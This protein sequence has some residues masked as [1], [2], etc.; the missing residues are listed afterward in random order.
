MGSV[1][2]LK[3]RRTSRIAA[4]FG[5]VHTPARNSWGH[6]RQQPRFYDHRQER[7]PPSL[8]PAFEL[9]NICPRAR[10]EIELPCRELDN[11]DLEVVFEGTTVVIPSGDLN[12]P[13]RVAALLKT[14]FNL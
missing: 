14:E 5:D 11:G 13:D 1:S 2:T 9:P 6:S 12:D 7:Q 3:N 8:R 4:R 10:N